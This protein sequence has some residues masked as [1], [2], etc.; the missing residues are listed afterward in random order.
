MYLLLSVF[1]DGVDFACAAPTG[2]SR[3][4]GAVHCQ[5]LFG[6]WGLGQIV[7]TNIQAKEG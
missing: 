2:P 3:L 7:Q 1:I 5:L 4:V 6:G